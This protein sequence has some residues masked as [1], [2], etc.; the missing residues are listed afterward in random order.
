M[1]K[2]PQLLI[3]FSLLWLSFQRCENNGIQAGNSEMCT[4]P[5]N[6]IGKNCSIPAYELKLSDTSLPMG[7]NFTFAYLQP[8]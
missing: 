1:S 5:P 4:C 8:E 3:I 2:T 6:F 7:A